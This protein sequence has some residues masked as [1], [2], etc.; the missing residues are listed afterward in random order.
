MEDAMKKIVLAVIFAVTMACA[1]QQSLAA[2]EKAAS[3]GAPAPA[4]AEKS[5]VAVQAP[6]APEEVKIS[7]EEII[8]N[9][10][11]ILLNRTNIVVNGVK[12]EKK[13]SGSIVTYNGK[14][15][16]DLDKDTLMVILRQVNQ[17][18][19]MQNMENLNRQMRAMKQLDNL[20]KMQRMSAPKTYSPPKTTTVPKVPK[21]TPK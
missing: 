6:K 13:D 2:D 5:A 16:E 9:L 14:R 3:P 7:K 12:V 20:N 21:S 11:N 18:V 1:A 4:P 15:L 19:S 10:N 17:Q 8:T